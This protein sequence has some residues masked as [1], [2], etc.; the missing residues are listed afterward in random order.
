MVGVIDTVKCMAKTYRFK[1][2]IAI[3]VIY[4]LHLLSFIQLIK[5]FFVELYKS[6]GIF[7]IV[8]KQPQTFGPYCMP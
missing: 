2:W 4:I 8:G 6:R 5:Y 7:Q 3:A 1:S